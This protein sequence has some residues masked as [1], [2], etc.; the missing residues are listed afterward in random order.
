MQKNSSKLTGLIL[1]ALF[2][3]AIAS[4][5]SVEAAPVDELR[6]KISTKNAEI[7]RIEAE[8]KKYESEIATT[9]KEART[10]ANAIDELRI[11]QRK[12]EAEINVTNKKIEQTNF[13]ID[14]L[15]LEIGSKEK[16]IE[17]HYQSMAE[18]M[19]ELSLMGNQ[20]IL[21][22]LL[23]HDELGDAWNEMQTIREV[24]SGISQNLAVLKDEKLSLEENRSQLVSQHKQLL[25]LNQ[26]LGTRKQVATTN[27]KNQESLLAQTKSKESNY[28][29]LLAERQALKKQFE[30]EL[31]DFESQLQIQINPGS[32]PP[33]G[34]GVLSWPLDSVYVTQRFGVTADS[35]RLY[36]SGSHNGVDFR[37]APG[38]NVKSAADGVV[39][40]VGNTDLTCPNASYGNWVLIEHPNG[41]STLYGHLSAVRVSPGERVARGQSIAYSGNTGYSTAPHLHMTVYASE[42]VRITQL[43][44]KA[45]SGAVYTVPL[46]PPPGYLDPLVYL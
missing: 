37:A 17:L 28:K 44:S 45:C 46:A 8:I 19:R 11:A 14:E 23:S 36:A 4:I 6:A 33:A 2:A 39:K 3:F 31:R 9:Q 32:Y 15:E 1:S 12:I 7:A 43:P 35:G 30:T 26:E 24:E 25:N 27:K 5:T 42:G 20:T 18:G 22:V 41:L 10:L 40:G 13:T 34:K 16:S 29:T 38:T 21:E